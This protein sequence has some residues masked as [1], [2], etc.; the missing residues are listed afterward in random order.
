[1]AITNYNYS[2]TN[3]YDPASGIFRNADT[4]DQLQKSLNTV[5]SYAAKAVYTNKLSK[6]AGY[7]IEYGWKTSLAS[8]VFKTLNAM[9]G[10]YE[11]LIDS[12]SNDYSFRVNT[13]IAGA[14]FSWNKRKINI[15]AGIKIFFTGFEQGANDTHIKTERHFIN[16]APNANMT[17]QL[18]ENSSISFNYAGY[19]FQPSVDQ[20]QPLRKSSNQLYVQIGNPGLKPG[21]NH[22][23]GL[24]YNR[25][26]WMK[27]KNLSAT[28]SMNYTTNNITSKTS[29]DIQGRSISQYININTIPGISGNIHYSWQYKKIGLRPSVSTSI[30]RYGGY[31]I[32]ND[33]KV[34]NE[35]FHGAVNISLQYDW[36]NK[37]TA[38]Y[39]GS[40]NYNLGWSDIANSTTNRNMSHTHRV[41]VTGYLP[42]KIEINSDCSLTFQPKNKVFNSALNIVRWN[43]VLQKKFFNSEKVIVKLA[44]EDILN[45]NTG[46]YRSVYGSNVYESNRLVIKRYWLATVVWNFSKS[47]NKDS[48]E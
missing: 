24:N 18:K 12:L 34:K 22:S 45:K 47:I 39:V 36:A 21:F 23:A 11:Q 14:A 25:F 41:D 27:G 42:A 5:E 3:L 33:E 35:S 29:T 15:A 8:N 16:L 2:V 48:N 28:L 7:S 30:N 40:V 17:V 20:L 9:N 37:L 1:M 43:A 32:L 26:D 19:T 10:K 6:E 38:T 13:H 4:L 31:S 46:Y 44:I